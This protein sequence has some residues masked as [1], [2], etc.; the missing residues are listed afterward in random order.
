MLQ[1]KEHALYV[2]VNM[3]SGSEAQKAAVMA[4]GWPQQL[5]AHMGDAEPRVR[6]AAVW[7]V[8]NLS[9]RCTAG[10][11]LGGGEGGGR[12]QGWAS[13]CKKGGLCCTRL[14][15]ELQSICRCSHHLARSPHSAYLHLSL[16]SRITQLAR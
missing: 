6:E 5:L 15:P 8:I 14:R 12:A 9:W 13:G 2:V 16:T 7:A 10:W 4:G 3:A 1:L 11:W